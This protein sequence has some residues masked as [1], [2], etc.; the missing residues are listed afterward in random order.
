MAV[1]EFFLVPGSW[2]HVLIIAGA[3]ATWIIWFVLFGIM[4]RSVD[5][6]TLSDRM[7]KRLLVGSVLELLVALPMH[8]VARRRGYCCAGVLTGVGLGLG[9]TVMLL[10]LGPAVFF[11]IFRRYRQAYGSR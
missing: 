10:A 4:A 8:L 2:P 3:I 1:Y 5:R 7:Y 6:L 9:I 11:L